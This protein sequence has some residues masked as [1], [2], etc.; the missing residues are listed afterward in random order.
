MEM[1]FSLLE[2]SQNHLDIY[3]AKN[4]SFS[5]PSFCVPCD[6]SVRIMHRVH[7][8]DFLQHMKA[9]SDDSSKGHHCLGHEANMAPGG[10]EIAM[11]AAG[12]ALEALSSIMEGKVWVASRLRSTRDILPMPCI[13]LFLPSQTS[14]SPK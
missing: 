6:L 1:L 7:D 9:C 5:P 14:P 8:A 3:P 4:E 13:A 2:S 11:L 12:G 10:Y